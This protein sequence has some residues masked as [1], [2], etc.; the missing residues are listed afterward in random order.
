MRTAMKLTF[1]SLVWVGLN[2][3]FGLASYTLPPVEN[4]HGANVSAVAPVIAAVPRKPKGFRWKWALI[5]SLEFLA[6][7]HGDRLT[8]VKTR[9]AL[10]GP[11]FP[12]WG[13]SI[14]NIHGWGDGDP[15]LTNYIAHPMQGAASG[16]I[17]IRNDPKGRNVQFGRS[18]QYWYSRLKALAWAAGYSTQFE[19]GPI[20]EATIGHVGLIKGTAGFVDLFVTPLAGFGLMVAEDA[21]N[22]YVLEKL[23]AG[24]NNPWKLTAYRVFF[25]PSRT[26][27]TALAGRFPWDPQKPKVRQAAV[28]NP[29]PFHYKEKS[30]PKSID[31]WNQLAWPGTGPSGFPQVERSLAS[32]LSVKLRPSGPKAIVIAQD[33]LA[34]DD[35]LAADPEAI[36]TSVPIPR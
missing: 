31:G 10:G 13:K 5:E 16:F 19:I 1:I 11:F 25:N 15:I 6:V 4:A 29:I 18:K 14:T 30:Q 33:P 27:A 21:L 28:K 22:R 3:T 12:D 24:T 9:Q 32:C 2:S 26:F 17:Q 35:R 23:V 7:E 20:S 8:Q 36:G 34:L